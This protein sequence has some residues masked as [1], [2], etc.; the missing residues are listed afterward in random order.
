MKPFIAVLVVLLLMAG[1]AG[2]YFFYYP[3][4]LMERATRGTLQQ[5]A[6]AVVT[7][8]RARV[9]EALQAMLT[10]DARI[11]L[12]I[13]FF[14]VGAQV[15]PMVQDFDKPE[16]MRFIDNILFS[17]TAYGYEPEL[18]TFV[19][20]DDARAAAVTFSS[21][22]WADGTS[23]YGGLSVDMRFSSTDGMCK[24]EVV[25][26]GQTPRLRLADCGMTLMRVPKPGQAEKLRGEAVRDF[27]LKN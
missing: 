3:P 8:D 10:D 14:T 23:H 26:E 13:R 9:G 19:L 6:D 12:E 5:F 27:L 1:G 20:S 21:R 2:Y 11:K 4:V 7:Q 24:G 25:F 18:E 15:P 17:M 16:F 22:H